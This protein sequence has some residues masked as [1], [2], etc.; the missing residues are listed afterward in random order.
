MSRFSLLSGVAAIA[1]TAAVG[2]SACAQSVRDFNV[3]AGPM[4]QALTTFATQSD[5]QIFFTSDLVA[6]LKSPGVSGR[7]EPA[8]ALSRLLAGSGLTWTESR[9]GMFALQRSASANL[10]DA[11]QIDDVIVTGTL[12]RKSGDLASPIVMVNQSEIDRRGYGNVADALVDLP[13]NYSGAATPV[14]QLSGANRGGS[15]SVYATGVNLRGLG[16]SATL[17]LVNGRRL[18]GTGSRAEFADIST[19]P[20]GAV[21]RVD[22]LL[23]GASALY[24]ADAV[25]GVVNVI[26]RRSFDGNESRVR[27]AAARGGAEDV[28]LSHLVGSSWNEGSAYLSYEYQTING[29]S[30]YDRDYT[31]DGDLRRFGGSDWRGLNSSPGNILAFNASAGAYVSLFAIRPN[32]SGVA[33]SPADFAPG[34]A[35]LQLVGGGIDLLPTVERHSAYARIRQSISDQLVLSGDVRLN[36]RS[37]DLAGPGNSGIYTVTRANPHFVSPTGGASHTIGYSFLSELGP[38]RQFGSS[39]SLGV[40]AGLDYEI[41][42]S[43]SLEGYVTYAQERAKLRSTNRVNSRFLNEALG[44]IPDDPATPFRASVDGYANLFGNGSANNRAVLDFI[45]SGYSRGQDLSR[46]Q[47]ANLLAQGSLFSLPSG[48]VQLAIGVQY[49]TESL[50]GQSSFLGSTVRP[51]VTLR[52]RRQRNVSALFGEMRAPLVIAGERPGLRSLEVSLAARHEEY[53]D[54]GTTTNP[55]FGVVWSPISTLKVRGSWGTSFRAASLPQVF[56]GPGASATFLNRANGA[57]TLTLLL[58]GGNPDLRPETSETFTAGFDFQREDG[59][60]LG[61]TYFDTSFEDRIALPVTENIAGV[62]FDPDLSPFV[63]LINPIAN[64]SDL[65]LIQG[66]A[67]EPWFPTAYPVNTYGAIV[68]ARWLNTGAVRVRGIDFSARRAIEYL[69]QRFVLDASGSYIIDF[70]SQ[71]TPTAANR[72]VV[73]LTGYPVSLRAR[74]GMSWSRADWGASLHWS[75]IDGAQDRL[76]KRIASWRTVDGS[77]SW[78]AGQGALSG[79]RATLSIQNLLDEDPPFYDAPS[80]FGFDPGQANLLGRQVALQLTRRW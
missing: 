10:G 38:I 47:S 19:L 21:E 78:T 17:V 44:T 74:T 75:Y 53:D 25:A 77:V 45:S 80:G 32:A 13:Q 49:R 18:A 41:G 12:L 58:T 15:N 60:T 65:A 56:D 1:C 34:E 40:T 48:D 69:D 27:L 5:Q 22:V 4:Q 72:S 54:F 6:G 70:D 79:L 20:T 52:P 36:H 30:A 57:R 35:N 31:A 55:K 76:G 33:Q 9:P 46:A 64:P 59:L 16:P 71:V 28:S 51:T 43:W 66:L 23:D 2:T 73:G 62:L 67:A 42:G 29:L 37:Y 50:E 3:P 26:M 61:L 24:G 7:M 8:A 14:V 63:T 11:T 39:E 68:D